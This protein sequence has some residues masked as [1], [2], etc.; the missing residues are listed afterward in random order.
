M[1]WLFRGATQKPDSVWRSE[2]Y[3]EATAA[4]QQSV[5]SGLEGVAYVLCVTEGD[6]LTLQ[7]RAERSDEVMST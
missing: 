2:A 4:Y 7:A 6:A 1:Q 5:L 3:F